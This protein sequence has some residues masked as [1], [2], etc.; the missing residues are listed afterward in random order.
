[1][2][3]TIMKSPVRMLLLSAVVTAL[4]SSSAHSEAQV[5][6][7]PAPVEL[8]DEESLVR[9]ALAHNPE[10]RVE[11][12][13][14]DIASAGVRTASALENPI[15][16]GEWL[17]VQTPAEYGFGV[18]IEWT[19]PRPG[20]YGSGK[21]AARAQVRAVKADYRE[22]AADLEASVRNDY[23]ELDALDAEI[24][25]SEKSVDTRRAVRDVLEQRVA[26]GASSRIELS[27]AAV[28]LARAEQERDLLRSKRAS[29]LT[30]LE[31][32]LGLEPER[33]LDVKSRAQTNTL[34]QAPPAPQRSA[35][36]LERT[37][38][39][40]R[41]ELQADAARQDAADA[42]LSGERAKRWPWL[43][44]QGR[45]RRHDQSSYPND[46]TLG[47]QMTLPI[48]DRN[49]GPIAAAEATRRERRD[50]AL[51]H[52]LSIAR[53][54]RALH[55]ESERRRALADH[56]AEA[57]AP[58]LREHAVLV[59][60]ALLGMELDL[61][62][63]LSAEELVTRGGV[64]YLEARLAQRRAEIALARS[65]GAYGKSSTTPE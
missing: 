50:A 17:H 26:Q 57:I 43:A 6:A 25:L 48:F 61:T 1:M 28:S 35:A 63:L 49:P 3:S 29:Q 2:A 53:D 51:A 55:A 23:A 15:A 32:L 38:L 27:L 41:P 16:R 36:D 33:T 14:Q 22:R 11:R 37:A 30:A 9:Y 64:E 4:A 10:L 20:V 24:A 19:P 56:Y 31:A 21:D 34:G 44:L 42:N 46:V 39:A 45:Y 40:Q 59:K 58:V 18:G 65:V 54:V 62:A 7:S 52:R 47:V 13:E 60:Q 12:W 5:T 8:A